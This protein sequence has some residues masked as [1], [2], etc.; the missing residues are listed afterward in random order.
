MPIAAHDAAYVVARTE[1]ALS[2]IG[3]YVLVT[4]SYAPDSQTGAPTVSKSWVVTGG[5]TVRNEV[6]G[7]TGSPVMG[8]VIT[9][10]AKATTVVSIDYRARTW[11]T[12]TQP[13]QTSPGPG[14]LGQTPA[15]SAQS[16]QASLAAGTATLVGRATVEGRSTIEVEIRSSQWV[17]RTSVDPSSYPPVQEVDTAPGVAMTSPQAIRSD[18]EWLPP[19]AG[20]LALV[21]TTAA[22]PGGFTQAPAPAAR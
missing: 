9:T 22:I 5:N 18:Y 16:L 12:S 21:T 8:S 13:A 6:L 20:N 3:R 2:G 15:Q 11:S 19:T 7:T 4:T 10:T 1:T 14:P 17:Q